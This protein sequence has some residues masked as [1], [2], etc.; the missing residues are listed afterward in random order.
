MSKLPEGQ[1]AGGSGV[2]LRWVATRLTKGI[3]LLDEVVAEVPP[4][5]KGYT[6]TFNARLIEIN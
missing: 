4:A 1:K 2:A 5:E 6:V 3:E